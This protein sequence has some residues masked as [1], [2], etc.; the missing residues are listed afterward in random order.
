MTKRLKEIKQINDYVPLDKKFYEVSIKKFSNS[1]L[2]EFFSKFW[3]LGKD[4]KTE[5]HLQFILSEQDYRTSKRNFWTSIIVP[6]SLAIVAIIISLLP[7]F[8]S[9]F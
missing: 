5:R 6:S 7:I 1:E 4:H 8:K 3:V 2:D 9:L